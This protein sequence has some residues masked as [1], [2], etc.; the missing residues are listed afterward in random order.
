[1]QAGRS[2]Y[3]GGGRRGGGGPFRGGGRG[4]FGPRHPF[5]GGGF[6]PPFRGRGK[7]RGRVQGQGRG[8]LRRFAPYSASSSNPESAAVEDTELPEGEGGESS[9]VLP[10][11][12]GEAVVAAETSPSTV[13]PGDSAPNWQ[14]SQVAWCELCRV[15]CTSLE[16][17]EQHKNGKRHKKNLQ[18]IE[19]LKKA[20]L[21][22]T[23]MPNEF[24]PEIAHEGEDGSE[25]EGGGDD[26]V[27]DLPSEAVGNEN[28]MEGEQKNDVEQPETP[29]EERLDSQAG[30]NP[31]MEHFDNRRHGMKRR[32]RG[33]RGGGKRMKHTFEGARRPTE[34]PPKP[35]VVIPLICD[36]CNVKC[37]TQEVFDRHLSGKKHIGKLKR[38]EGHQAMYGPMGLQALYPPNPI[39]Q[40]LLQPQGHQQQQGFYGPPPS[41]FTPQGPPPYMLP[42][43][44][45]QAA[46]AP[47]PLAAAVPHFHPGSAGQAAV[48]VT[49]VHESQQQSAMV[50]SGIKESVTED[51]MKYVNGGDS[52]SGG[53]LPNLM[54]DNGVTRVEQEYAAA[55]PLP[56]S[57]VTAVH[58]DGAG[59]DIQLKEGA[60]E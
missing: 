48:T 21:T 5:R 15:D 4:N 32:M 45:P 23:E 18:R 39:A 55:A 13:A 9:G 2:P 37:D 14:P 31:R 24:H 29:T 43:P 41:S 52:E 46:A 3:R 6:G 42:P 58:V 38:F 40:T 47:P 19:E 49:V 7:G 33:G 20:N 34:P 26:Q 36:L 27:K 54:H 50:E 1:M 16:I 11:E 59:T 51:T 8:S 17:L 10:E 28:E 56:D 35:K 60:A 53:N 22:G 25:D 30:G 44:P 12:A 57:G